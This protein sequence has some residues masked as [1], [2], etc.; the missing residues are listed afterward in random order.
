MPAPSLKGL[1]A[2]T[3]ARLSGLSHVAAVKALLRGGIRIVQLRDKEM[4]SRRYY[5]TACELKKLCDKYNAL[6]IVNDRV[7]IAMAAGA[8]GV[9]LGQDDMPLAYARK[10]LGPE[11]ILGV[12]TSS[13]EQAMAAQE[14]GAD[15]IG[16]GP[17]FRTTTK[18]AGRSIG[19]QPLKD[20]RAKLKLPIAAIGGI[21]PDNAYSVLE[22]G[23][24]MLAVVS[25]VLTQ[26]RVENLA[27]NFVKKIACY[28]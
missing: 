12:S 14:N 7:D 5:E 24:D 26:G 4:S 1:Y 27:R 23:A 17:I 15:Y 16:F 2:L 10:I 18:D 22:A 11:F 28:K 9:H 25:S 20:V 8:D 13:I 3:D 6:F 19:L 21:N